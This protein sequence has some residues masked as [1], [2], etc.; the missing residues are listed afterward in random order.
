MKA[1]TFVNQIRKMDKLIENKLYE[2]EHWKSVAMG[3][4]SHSNGERVQA[5]GNKEKMADAVGKYIDME[6]EL[7]ED[8]D[9]LVFKKREVI[10]TIEKLN[11][12]EYDLLHKIYVQ[13][14]TF[15]EVASVYSK[16]YSWVTALHG[17]AL[18]NLQKILD[19]NRR[20]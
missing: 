4:S 7:N 6:K 8:I 18:K 12:T 5:S 9:V 3:I 13:N 10:E 19:R 11:Y 14:M 17:R 20:E 1:K 16:S 2:I 15:D